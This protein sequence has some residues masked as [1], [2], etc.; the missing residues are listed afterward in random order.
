MSIRDLEGTRYTDALEQAITG[1]FPASAL[2]L[3]VTES[4]RLNDAG[5]ALASLRAVRDL[6]ARVALDGFGTGHASLLNLTRLSVDL[7][8]I[9]RPFLQDIGRDGGDRPDLLGGIV[10]LARHLGVMT[11]AQGIERPDQRARLV[12][13]GCELGQGFLLSRPLE[14]ARAQELLHAQRLRAEGLHADRGS[15]SAPRP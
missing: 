7:L 4:A 10:A 8:K 15:R 9:P 13:L 11:V 6:G 5:G 1:A 3:E 2:I 12:E 14:A